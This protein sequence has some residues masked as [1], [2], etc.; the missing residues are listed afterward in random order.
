MALDELFQV[1][2]SKVSK[3]RHWRWHA[4]QLGVACMPAVLAALYLTEVRKEM[5]SE[6]ERKV[7]EKAEKEAIKV[8]SCRGVMHG[9]RARGWQAAEILRKLPAMSPAPMRRVRLHRPTRVCNRRPCH[10][11]PPPYPPIA[12]HDR[13]L[14][15]SRGGDRT[16]DVASLLQ[17]VERLEAPDT[18]PVRNARPLT[19]VCLPGCVGKWGKA[20]RCPIICPTSLECDPMVP[21]GGNLALQAHRGP[22]RSLRGTDGED[23]AATVGPAVVPPQRQEEAGIAEKAPGTGHHVRGQ[24]MLRASQRMT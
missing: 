5:D 24:A 6:A 2:E 9:L 15:P 4:W 14:C 10:L 12:R 21:A 16:E 22:G 3:R 20:R 13:S 18:L 11:S 19:T 17:R 7:K 8:D 23:V 1:A